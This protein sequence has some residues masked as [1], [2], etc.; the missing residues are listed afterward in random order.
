MLYH[1]HGTG[2]GTYVYRQA[3]ITSIHWRLLL[4]D[5]FAFFSA[6]RTRGTLQILQGQGGGPSPFAFLPPRPPAPPTPAHAHTAVRTPPPVTP[7]SH[8]SP[9]HRDHPWLSSPR[10][11]H[12]RR[13]SMPPP[14]RTY[15]FAH[16]RRSQSV[17]NQRAPRSLPPPGGSNSCARLCAIRFTA[18]PGPT[19]TARPAADS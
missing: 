11:T 1:G 3:A 17:H 12:L 14:R 7:G 10:T 2:V 6:S 18:T 8:V 19:R 9:L 5:V 13:Y 4:L 15:A 16:P